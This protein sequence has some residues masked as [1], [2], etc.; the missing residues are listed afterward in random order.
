MVESAFLAEQLDAHKKSRPFGLPK[1]SSHE[2]LSFPKESSSA[3]PFL[4]AQLTKFD[5]NLSTFSR[6]VKST[7]STQMNIYKILEYF[8]SKFMIKTPSGN[9]WL[10]FEYSRIPNQHLF[11]YL[12]PQEYREESICWADFEIVIRDESTYSYQF[13]TFLN[14]KLEINRP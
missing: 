6:P 12:P 2:D 9:D 1:E 10:R 5:G 7:Q 4:K 13:Y 8:E 3:S 14:F 11:K